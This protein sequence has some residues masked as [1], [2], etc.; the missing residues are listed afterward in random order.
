MCGVAD[1]L[2]GLPGARVVDEAVNGPL[3]LP[4]DGLVEAPERAA[5]LVAQDDL[6][7]HMERLQASFRLDVIPGDERLAGVDG[8]ACLAGRGGIGEVLKELT[9]LLRCQTL[10]FGGEG[11]RH[12]GGQ[13]GAA[14][15]N[16]DD[17]PAGS[18]MR[19][20]SNCGRVLDRQLA[21]VWIV[22]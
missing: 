7:S 8:G 13:P 14:L 11:G 5:R 12:D 18:L 3:Y 15:R 21:H 16:I 19:R 20:P 9:E 2:R 1:K 17:L 4:L 10:E 6:V 22:S